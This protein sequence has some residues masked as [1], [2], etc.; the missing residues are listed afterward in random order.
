[1][2]T[3]IEVATMYNIMSSCFFGGVRT[4]EEVRYALRLLK[5]SLASSVHSNLPIFFN[6][7]KKGSP[8]SPSHDMKRL[9]YTMQSVSFYTSLTPHGGPISIIAWICLVLASIPW[10]L[11]KNPSSCPDGTPNTHLFGFN[12]HFHFFRFSKV[13]FKSSISVFG[14][15]CLYYYIVHI[16][17]CILANLL[18][19][20][21]LDS[22]LVSS[23]RV[24][25][26]KWHGFVAVGAERSDERCL[27]LFFF[28]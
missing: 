3:T 4:G 1:M 17:F 15:F 26:S 25:E 22:S 28:L 10:W 6:N 8:F 24:I 7:L 14:F 20:A 13:C 16:C 23:A 18:T 21:C 11:N 19:K 12:F 5:A 9:R 27:A 2:L